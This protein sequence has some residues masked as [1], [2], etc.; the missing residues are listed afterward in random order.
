MKPK[1]W[2]YTVGMVSGPYHTFRKSVFVLA[3]RPV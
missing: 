2:E 1:Q 3:H